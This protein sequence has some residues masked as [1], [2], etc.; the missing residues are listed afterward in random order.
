MT[1]IKLY[2]Q[3]LGFIYDSLSN[4][5]Y[6]IPQDKYEKQYNKKIAKLKVKLLA[7]QLCS[8]VRYSPL[9]EINKRFKKR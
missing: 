1:T 3:E 4:L 2:K 7:M 8:K 5:T 9:Q 6:D